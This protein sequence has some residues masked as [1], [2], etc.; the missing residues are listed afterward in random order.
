M[1][2]C[3]PDEAPSRLKDLL[4]AEATTATWRVSIPQAPRV[5]REACAGSAGLSA[6]M[7]ACGVPTDRLLEARPSH[8]DAGRSGLYVSVN[9][10]DEPD[11]VDNLGLQIMY[12][13]C[14]YIHF[15]S[16]CTSWSNV[17]TFIGGTR[18]N[19]LPLRHWALPSS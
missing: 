15:G 8:D 2:L 16:P 19:D 17:D 14:L 13:L 9:D 11:V 3:R 10:L 4:H 1:P 6:A 12:G 7:R 5:F 18:C